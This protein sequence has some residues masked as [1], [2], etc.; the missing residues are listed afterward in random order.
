[1]KGL[2]NL[3][4]Q[5]LWPITK[6]ATRNRKKNQFYSRSG[7]SEAVMSTPRNVMGPSRTS[8]PRAPRLFTASSQLK[9]ARDDP[10]IHQAFEPEKVCKYFRLPLHSREKYVKVTGSISTLKCEKLSIYKKYSTSS[11]PEI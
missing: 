7:L 10:H 11:Q 1:M 4:Q 3:R 2:T 6:P 9:I 5:L 8:F